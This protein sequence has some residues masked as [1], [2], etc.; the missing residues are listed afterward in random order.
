MAEEAAAVKVVEAEEVKAEEQAAPAAAAEAAKPEEAEEKP[1]AA[2]DAAADGGE[3]E[4]DE[5]GDGEEEEPEAEAAVG[6]KRGREDGA[7]G[8]SSGPIKLGYRTFANGGECAEFFK[9][10]LAS[11]PKNTDLNEVGVGGVVVAGRRPAACMR[12]GRGRG[13]AVVVVAAW[14]AGWE[15]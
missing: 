12:R 13:A 11:A 5:E 4:E 7:S 2:G 10:L 15:G 1:A 14:L 3:D 9:K 8:S 6:S